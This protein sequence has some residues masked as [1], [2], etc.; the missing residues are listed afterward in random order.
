MRNVGLYCLIGLVL[1]L[2]ACAKIGYLFLNKGFWDREQLLPEKWV[3]E[4]TR[5]YNRHRAS[6]LGLRLPVVGPIRVSMGPPDL[7]DR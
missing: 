5:G 4:S 7:E 3:E 1:V 6:F 2:V